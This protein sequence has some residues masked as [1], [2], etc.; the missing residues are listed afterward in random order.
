MFKTNLCLFFSFYLFISTFPICQRTLLELLLQ[1]LQNAPEP[2]N[3]P[4][5]T[6]RNSKSNVWIS[7]ESN[8][9]SNLCATAYPFTFCISVFYEL[10]FLF[11]FF[12][13]PLD[14]S[15]TFLLFLVENKGVEPLT[16]CVQ[17]RCSSQLS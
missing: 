16:L 8:P 1:V 3:K 4:F 14:S 6:L 5:L 7:Q 9:F 11:V 17:G 12:L 2:D 13:F 15:Q 10:V